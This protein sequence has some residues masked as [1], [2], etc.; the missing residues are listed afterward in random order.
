M[1]EDIHQSNGEQARPPVRTLKRGATWLILSLLFIA[2]VST[3]LYFYKKSS[4]RANAEV[5]SDASS[6]P[7]STMAGMPMGNATPAGSNSGTGQIYIAPE[8][9]QLIGVKTASA[10]VMPVI[11]EIRTVGRVSYDETRIT[12]VHTKVSG[13]IEDVFADYVGKPVKAGEPLFTIYSPDLVATQQEYLLALK[14]N[15]LLKDSAFPWVSGGSNNLVE[16]AKQRL[17]LWDITP[18]EIQALEQRGEVQRALT[19]QSHVGGV[20]TERQAYHHGRY[21]TPEMDLYT[22]VDLS[23]VWVL[24]QVNESDLPSVAVGQMVQIELPYS[25]NLNRRQGRIVFISPTLDPKTRAAEV[26]VEFANPD[27]ALKP[28]MFV[29]FTLKIPLGRQLAIPADALLD[30]GTMQ[31]VFVDKGQGYFEP[32][33]VK[34]GARTS[35]VVSIE[36]GLKAREQVVTAANF[37]LDSESRLRGAFANMGEPS[38]VPVGAPAPGTQNLQ[39]EVLEPKTAKPGSNVIRILVKDSSGKPIDGAD[40]QVGLFMPQMGNMPP[41]SSDATL[42]PEGGGVYSGSIQ[43]LMAWT[44]ETT[45]TAKKNGQVVGTAKTTITAR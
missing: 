25:S 40:I 32:R 18:E 15:A 19:I 38:R 37:I 13:Y 17:L 14:S 31:Y 1:T 11:K 36:S 20:V 44:W 26:R 45:V 3:S 22:I 42:K 5:G 43:F 39:V 10:E 6:R 23:S 34:V 2:A 41:M 33:E 9:Q 27:L 12:H 30:T 8:R 7:D 28:D 21:V 24:G 4:A 35:D 29:N 16:A